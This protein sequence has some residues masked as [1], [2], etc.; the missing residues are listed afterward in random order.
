MKSFLFLSIGVA[1]VTI[2]SNPMVDALTS[3]TDPDN[4]KY[5]SF[6][7]SDIGQYIPIPGMIIMDDMDTM[8]KKQLTCPFSCMDY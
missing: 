4:R 8:I 7:G 1:L 3:L 2:F 6:S 5:H